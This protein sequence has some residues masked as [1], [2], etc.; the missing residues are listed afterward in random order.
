MLSKVLK[1]SLCTTL[2]FGCKRE[3]A[4][5]HRFPVEISTAGQCDIPIYL[6]GVGHLLAFEEIEIHPEVEGRIE[7]IYYP[8]GTFVEKGALLVEIDDRKYQACEE[9]AKAKILEEEARVRF[10]TAVVNRM[11]ELVGKDYVSAIEYEGRVKDLEESKQRLEEAHAHHKRCKIN[12]SHTKIHAPISGYLSE[13]RLDEGNFITSYEA[14]LM[15]L[16]RV[17]PIVVD[18]SLPG[19]HLDTIKEHQR[20]SPLPLTA[21]RCV[22]NCPPLEG[23]LTFVQSRIHPET[24]MLQ[25]RGEIA[26]LEERGWPG[27]FVRVAL[28]LGTQKNA[29]VVL[30]QA[31]VIGEEK[32][33]IF[34]LSPEEDSVEM[35]E[36]KVGLAHGPCIEILEG[37]E[38]DEKIVTDGQ[39]NLYDGAPVK[40]MATIENCCGERV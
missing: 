5:V 33:Y 7:R 38:K 8:D 12:L 2:L 16:R 11:S 23:K 21:K 14:P 9:E 29:I 27:E 13:R 22:P 1:L 20:V 25:L 39:I 28:Q 35:R 10:C 3:E 30:D 18:F 34:V 26:N 6:K 32:K 17:S 31:I 24:G 36:V 37:I 40:V 4:P 19:L 15:T